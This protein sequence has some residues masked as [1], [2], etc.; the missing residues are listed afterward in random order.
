M[1]GIF[2]SHSSK[3][4]AEAE[5]VR[6]WLEQQGWG[7]SQVF[8]DVLELKSGDEWRKVL[9]AMADKEAVIVC[10]SD[11]WLLSHECV[12]EFTQAQERGKPIFPLFVKPVT[13]TLPRFITD[14]Q[15]GDITTDDGFTKLRDQLLAKRV[16]PQTFPWPPK[17]EPDRVVYRGLQPLDVQDAA[18]F[19]GRDADITRGLDQLRRMRG[20]APQRVLAILGAS[21]AG[22]SSFLRAGLIARLKRDEQNFLVFPVVRPERAALS[23]A[24]GLIASVSEATGRPFDLAT[25]AADLSEAFNAARAPIIERLRRDTEAAGETH[26]AGPPTVVIPIDQTEELFSAENAE[27]RAFC[28]L[29]AEAVVRDANVIIVATIRTDSYEAFQNGML[30]DRQMPFTLPAIAAGSFQEIIEGPSRLARPPFSVEPALTQQLL[31]DLD[32]ADALPLLAFTLE[33]LHKGQ[34]ADGR[35]T[36]ADYRDKLG[37]LSGAI[38]TAVSAVLG[39]EPSNTGLARR[40]F[41]PALVQVGE[42]GAKR[43]V[44]RRESIPSEAQGLADRFVAQRLLVT[45]GGDIEVA[46]EAILRQWPTLAG[47]I[48]EERDALVV[49]DGVRAVASEWRVH[50]ETSGRKRDDIWLLHR[51]DR[52]KNAETI[53]ARPDFCSLVD[54]GVRG[55]LAACRVAEDESQQAENFN[56]VRYATMD[57][58]SRPLLLMELRAIKAVSW[59]DSGKGKDPDF[60]RGNQWS[61]NK[62][63]IEFLLGSHDKWHPKPARITEAPEYRESTIGAYH[64]YPDFFEFPC[65]GTVVETISEPPSQFRSDGCTPIPEQNNRSD[66]TYQSEAVELVGKLVPDKDLDAAAKRVHQGAEGGSRRRR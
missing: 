65:C 46:H 57:Y 27:C 43:R 13:K 50:A 28:D 54:E 20:G 12:R 2:I 23:G 33:R 62:V 34:V 66:R 49:L 44:A 58:Y 16:M 32:T 26:T 55:Y 47:W 18:I 7:R 4:N 48:A 42:D 14:L 63:E 51:G 5:R 21:G 30:P 64:G 36:V 8:L 59:A 24:Q 56:A 38:L 17:G 37:G 19:F 1:G 35:L 9:D 3:N 31:T 11:E 41:I 29:V 39:N 53:A 60:G 40:L 6:G 22:K 25:A 61:R 45:D 15:I 52:L 10:L